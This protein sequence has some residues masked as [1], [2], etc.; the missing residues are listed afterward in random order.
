[1]HDFTPWSALLGGALIGLSASVLLLTTG[2]IAGVSGIASGLL[3]PQRGDIAWRVAFVTGLV[4]VGLTT[5]VFAP[6]RLGTSPRGFLGLALAGLLVG[7]GTKIGNGCTS[8]HGICGI[9]RLS[10]RSIV[11]TL[12]FVTTGIVTASVV[13]WLGGAG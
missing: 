7:V 10:I 13:R 9:S 1:M 8:G 3:L 4:L 12:L 2:R 5:G 6:D 11:A